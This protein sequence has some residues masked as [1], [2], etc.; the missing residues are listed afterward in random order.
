[1][2][3]Q[4]TTTKTTSQ[5]TEPTTPLPQLSGNWINPLTQ[6]FRDKHYYKNELRFSGSRFEWIQRFYGD[7][8]QKNTLFVV[9]S[10]GGYTLEDNP[11]RS[12]EFFINFQVRN[13]HITWLAKNLRLQ[14]E[15][16]FQSCGLRYK[17]EV[18]V[19]DEG[20]GFVADVGNCS[21]QYDILKKEGNQIYLGFLSPEAKNCEAAMRPSV[22]GEPLK[23]IH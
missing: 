8:E 17:K 7:S 6:G 10:E 13:R 4:S 20:C 14:R 22:F 2:G 19:S 15:F 18:T 16:N 3:C 1:M 11:Q 5:T 9:R 12:G 23:K 21:I